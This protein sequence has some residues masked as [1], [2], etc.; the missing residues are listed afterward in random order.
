MYDWFVLSMRM[1]VI[2]D[3]PFARPD[4][5]PIGGGKKGK[6][7]DWTRQSCELKRG[8]IMFWGLLFL[9]L[10]C[11]IEGMPISMDI[12]FAI[13][14]SASSLSPL[15]HALLY[16]FGMNSC[17]SQLH[18]SFGPVTLK[19]RKRPRHLFYSLAKFITAN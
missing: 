5:A 8:K 12:L 6:F 15:Y 4:L 13:Y 11:R 10:S 16:M 14:T 17:L 19:K 18:S 9:I 7:R 2:L 1:Q 3:S